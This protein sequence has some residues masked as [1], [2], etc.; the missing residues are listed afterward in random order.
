MHRLTILTLAVVLDR[1]P[2]SHYDH[3]KFGDGQ[4]GTLRF[5]FV[6]CCLAGHA[7]LMAMGARTCAVMPD[8]P[9][10]QTITGL[11]TEYLGVDHLT[12]DALLDP[13]PLGGGLPVTAPIA[14]AALRLL[15]RTGEVRWDEAAAPFF[16]EM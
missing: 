13:D 3:Q 1:M 4:L 5:V 16:A 2:A 14:A 10:G 12:M 8:Y 7:A 9:N 6:P 15:A 11:A